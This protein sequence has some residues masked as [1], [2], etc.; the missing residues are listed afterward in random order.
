[1]ILNGI[2]WIDFIINFDFNNYIKYFFVFYRYI[3][4]VKINL[5]NVIL[6]F[7]YKN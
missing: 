7:Y 4:K 5:S 1:M 3:N 2:K 6:F